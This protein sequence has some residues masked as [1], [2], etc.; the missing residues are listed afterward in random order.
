MRQCVE[1]REARGLTLPEAA[2]LLHVS[3]SYLCAVEA[4]H[5]RLSWALA[6]RMA[7][8]YRCGELQLIIS[9]PRKAASH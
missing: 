5:Q 8:L 4:G 7:R 1:F 3:Q 2:C 9:K 6:Q